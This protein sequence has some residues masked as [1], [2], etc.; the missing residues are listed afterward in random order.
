MNTQTQTN[1]KLPPEIIEKLRKIQELSQRGG[2]TEEAATATALLTTLLKK[3]GLTAEELQTSE[4]GK[5]KGRYEFRDL[6]ANPSQLQ[7]QIALAY[8]LAKHSS[9]EVLVRADLNTVQLFGLPVHVATA[10]QLFS[11]LKQALKR[12]N[13]DAWTL[14]IKRLAKTAAPHNRKRS[15]FD[16]SFYLGAV[17]EI[18]RRL[19]EQAEGDAV[20]AL[21]QTTALVV[22]RDKDREAA[23]EE[24]REDEGLVDA[25]AKRSPDLATVDELALELGM[26]AGRTVGLEQQVN[27]P[28]T[29]T[30]GMLES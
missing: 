28:A 17:A 21:P 26:E 10:T 4:R 27:G 19:C 22:M 7:W 6:K 23:Y 1:D 13:G 2:T 9:C 29:V 3:Y 18:Y 11:Y 25:P 15:T 30:K 5:R 24:S 12:L 14:Y 16:R 8:S 20:K